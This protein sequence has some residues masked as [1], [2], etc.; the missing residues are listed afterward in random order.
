VQPRYRFGLES[1]EGRA[2]FSVVVDG[3]DGGDV[4]EPVYT[5]TAVHTTATVA[6]TNP[7]TGAFNVAGKYSK[8]A[9]PI[10]NPDT[11]SKYHFAGSGTKKSLKGTFSLAGDVQ[12]PGFVQNGHS[13]GYLTITGSKGTIVLKVQG[14]PQTPG[15]PPSLFYRIVNGT[16]A[17]AHA[18][19]KGHI[20]VSASANTQKFLFR[21]NQA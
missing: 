4:A 11:G 19:G 5:T 14:P 21:F 10:G 16:G 2:L 17:Y 20:A 9:G 3:V 7:L 1:L 15:F 13:S 18:A 6:T 12:G 8:P